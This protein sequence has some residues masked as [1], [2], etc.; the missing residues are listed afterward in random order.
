[1]PLADIRPRRPLGKTQL[2]VSSIG[3]GTNRWKKGGNDA[4]VAETYRALLDGGLDFV[5]T[6]EIY[7]FGKSERLIGDCLASDK[8]PAFVASKF[9]P[10]LARTSPKKLLAALDSSL[11]RLGRKTIDLYYI[12]FPFPFANLDALTDALVEAV[13]AGK[14]RTVGV[15]NF[16]ADQMRRAADRLGRAGISLAA[17]EVHYCLLHRDAERNGVL[18]ACRETG[19]SLVAY[20]PLASGKLARGADAA[21]PDRSDQ[22]RRV[23]AE[24]AEQHQ[25]SAAQV[26]LA[27]LLARDPSIIP[28]PGATKAAHIRANIGALNVRLSDAEFARIDEASRNAA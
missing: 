20:F 4:A 19:A 22:L 27:W 3:V 26:A 2:D 11:A 24:I 23:L 9:A 5:D 21:K 12:H 18:D 14:A 17:N 7:G 6:A 8:R 1:M 28:I 10:F 16:G 13:K 25:A 15:S